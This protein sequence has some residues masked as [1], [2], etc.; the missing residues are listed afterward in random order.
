MKWVIDIKDYIQILDLSESKFESTPKSRKDVQ[1]N[2]CV[3]KF[4]DKY[5]LI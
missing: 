2:F 5:S 1:L 3:N 4:V